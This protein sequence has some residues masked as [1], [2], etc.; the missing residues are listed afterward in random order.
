MTALSKCLVLLVIFL[1]AHSGNT[2]I[3]MSSVPG[4]NQPWANHLIWLVEPMLKSNEWTNGQPTTSDNAFLLHDKPPSTQQLVVASATN[5]NSQVSTNDS[6]AYF[7]QLPVPNDGCAITILS[8]LHLHVPFRMIGFYHPTK[9]MANNVLY[10][11]LLHPIL[12]TNR[13]YNDGQANMANVS[14]KVFCF[15]LFQMAQQSWQTLQVS[16]CLSVERAQ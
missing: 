9:M 7:M 3:C 11:S 5:I 8:F 4:K 14:I 6:P 1:S 12:L 16:C 10:P 13:V 2:F 15:Y